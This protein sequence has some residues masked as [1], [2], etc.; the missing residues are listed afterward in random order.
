MPEK[1]LKQEILE[2]TQEFINENDGIDITVVQTLYDTFASTEEDDP[3]WY[4]G[5]LDKFLSDLKALTAKKIKERDHWLG[6]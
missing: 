5:G 4:G 2:T 3:F 6:L 1:T